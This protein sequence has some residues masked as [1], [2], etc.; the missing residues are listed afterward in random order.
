MFVMEI[1][2]YNFKRTWVNLTAA[3][4][5]HDNHLLWQRYQCLFHFNDFYI[6]A[7]S[8]FT[9]TVQ[10]WGSQT[11]HN[12]TQFPLYF[13][14]LELKAVVWVFVIKTTL[15]GQPTFHAISPLCSNHMAADRGCLFIWNCYISPATIQ[16]LFLPGVA[17][18]TLQ[19]CNHKVHIIV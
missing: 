2:P 12:L 8:L 9:V 16:P 10:V 7:L 11:K 6:A 5:I 13:F 1:M 14:L 15:D 18:L 19:S 17:I 3:L 4:Y